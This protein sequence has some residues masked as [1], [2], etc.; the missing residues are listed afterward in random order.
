MFISFD[1]KKAFEKIKHLFMIKKNL[2][3]IRD[4]RDIP[5]HNKGNFQQ[6][7]SQY[8]IKQ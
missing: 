2:G 1:A 7:Y 6:V 5:K 8:H 4:T 3:D